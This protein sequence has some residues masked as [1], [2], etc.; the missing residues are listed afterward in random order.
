LAKPI[1]TT[2]NNKSQNL[3]HS[4]DSPKLNQITYELSNTVWNI[5]FQQKNK[6]K[7]QLLP[8]V[9]AID[10]DKVIQKEYRALAAISYNLL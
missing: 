6:E 9:K 3:Y 2:F 5:Q 7:K 1:L 10:K 4:D 8:Y